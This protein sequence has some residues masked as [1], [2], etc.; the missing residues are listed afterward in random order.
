MANTSAS[1]G[2]DQVDEECSS[3]HSKCFS[4]VDLESKVLA[5]QTHNTSLVCD[6]NQCIDANKVLKSNEKDFQAKI[7]L[8]NRQLYEAEIA[9]LN[10]QD[11]ITSYLNTINEIKKNLA[12][13]ECDY[14][15]LAQ[16]LQSYE[17]SSYII[18]HMISKGTD[19]KKKGKENYQKCPPPILN[20]FVNSPDDKYVKYFQVKTPLVIDPIGMIT[21]EG[22]SLSEES[23][24]EGTV[25]D[26]VSDSE[27]E[28]DNSSDHV[29]TQNQT[30][31]TDHSR[32]D[33]L[34]IFTA[35]STIHV[36]YQSHQQDLWASVDIDCEVEPP[37]IR[38]KV[39]GHDVVISAEH[40]RRICGFQDSPDQPTLLDRY[41]VR[42]CFMRCK[43][44]GDLGAGIL[45]K[46]FMSP[47]FKYLAHVLIHCL[48]SRRGG[49]DDMRETISAPPA[50]WRWRHDD[51]N[52]ELEDIVAP[53][54]DDDDDDDVDDSAV[55]VCTVDVESVSVAEV[56]TSAGVGGSG[57]VD[58]DMDLGTL[59]DL[60]FLATTIASIST[61]IEMTGTTSAED[62]DESDD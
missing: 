21:D 35:I 2:T 40:I 14:E 28:S 4:C 5:Y 18:E 61:P 46:A 10:K 42:A 38:G 33:H 54:E 31:V 24:V 44:K 32:F 9:V 62:I 57:H 36:P 1:T 37:V 20:S 11:A 47:Q 25:E 49:F 43:Y 50:G 27:D 53:D 55:G 12:I 22:S 51:S 52:S 6:L 15:T 41:L 56:S 45:N 48:G 29:A 13:V 23:F 26:W 34:R 58:D 39:L 59:L 60:D 30:P 16:K 8:L 7:E 19:Q 17:S 3:L